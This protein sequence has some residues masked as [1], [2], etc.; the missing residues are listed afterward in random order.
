M[1]DTHIHTHNTQQL[2]HH[3]FRFESKFFVGAQKTVCG[4]E[5]TTATTWR[6]CFF[7][8]NPF[9]FVVFSP[10]SLDFFET[11]NT[12]RRG[13][14]DFTCVC[15]FVCVCVCV[16]CALDV[17]DRDR[18]NTH[19]SAPL[20]VLTKDGRMFVYYRKRGQGLIRPFSWFPP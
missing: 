1:D 5:N 20:L 2:F 3:H 19:C 17:V 4:G 14:K 7:Q 18:D 15:V 9:L 12:Q 8:S 13:T 6:V 11:H 10:F 16:C